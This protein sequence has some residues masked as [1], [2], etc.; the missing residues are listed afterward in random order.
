MLPFETPEKGP[1]KAK[2]PVI[3]EEKNFY[4]GV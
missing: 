1:E 4:A 2:E 3:A